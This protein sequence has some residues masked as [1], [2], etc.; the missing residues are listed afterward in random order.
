MGG[1]KNPNFIDD[2]IPNLN[3]LSEQM[4]VFQKEKQDAVISILI[5]FDDLLQAGS[6][7]YIPGFF[8]VI[9]KYMSV[10]NIIIK[11]RIVEKKEQ[12]GAEPIHMPAWGETISKGEL[13]SLIAYLIS[14]Y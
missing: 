3:R 5:E 12:G 2:T 6:Q 14:L 10:K 8:K 4:F 13:S 7:P 1:V 11:G 9:A